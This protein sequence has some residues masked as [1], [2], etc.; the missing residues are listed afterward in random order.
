MSAAKLN[1][2]TFETLRLLRSCT[3]KELVAQTGHG[4]FKRPRVVLKELSGNGLDACQ[5]ANVASVKIAAKIVAA[6]AQPALDAESDSD[7]G[8]E[9][10]A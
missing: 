9:Q 8:P 7:D 2:T 6:E 4:S 10:E 1:G 5:Q 3:Q